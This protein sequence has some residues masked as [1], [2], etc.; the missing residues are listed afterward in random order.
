MTNMRKRESQRHCFGAVI[1]AVCPS[2][3]RN[4]GHWQERQK[5]LR[6]T[7]SPP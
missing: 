5:S 6:G 3:D 1:V 2:H 7:G 4:F